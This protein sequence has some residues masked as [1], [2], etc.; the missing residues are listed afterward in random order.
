VFFIFFSSL[1]HP[2]GPGALQ[3]SSDIE[4]VTRDY[5]QQVATELGIPVV[6]QDIRV[7]EEA[8]PEE[9]GGLSPGAI[10]GIVLGVLF[11][12]GLIV[13]TAYWYSQ[14]KKQDPD[15]V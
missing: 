8:V 4:V 13:A 10:A 12:V 15:Y 11:V 1:S 2:Q 14:R 9:D 7:E 5:L 3:E 6:I